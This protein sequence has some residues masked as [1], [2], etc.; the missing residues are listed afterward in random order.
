MKVLD[1]S[2]LSAAASVSVARIDSNK[3][4][5]KTNISREIT[6]TERPCPSGARLRGILETYLPVNK[7]QFTLRSMGIYG[8]TC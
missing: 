1:I 8:E 3:F 5:R 4:T 7:F 2:T 6:R